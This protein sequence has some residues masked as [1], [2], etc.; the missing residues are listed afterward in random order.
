MALVS[1]KNCIFGKIKDPY[2]KFLLFSAKT[3]EK[4]LLFS[5]KTHERFLMIFA[6][7]IEADCVRNLVQKVLL[8][9]GSQ[10]E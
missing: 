10:I 7:R 8:F 6:K 3:G 4:F 1:F 9:R 5:A 2:L